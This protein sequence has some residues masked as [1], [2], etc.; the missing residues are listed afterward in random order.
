MNKAYRFSVQSSDAH[1]Y[2]Q[3]CQFPVFTDLG[4][5]KISIKM[6]VSIQRFTDEQVEKLFSFHKFVFLDVLQV[7]KGFQVADRS[8]KENS[9]FVVPLFVDSK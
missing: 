2:F 4:E 7:V 6:N 8:N 9:Y 5:V 3:I 1:T